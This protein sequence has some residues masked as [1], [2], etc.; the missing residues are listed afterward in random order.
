M[1][2]WETLALSGEG[3]IN[4]VNATDNGILRNQRSAI[5]AGSNEYIWIGSCLKLWC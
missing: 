3:S 1:S 4:S 2:L 5:W